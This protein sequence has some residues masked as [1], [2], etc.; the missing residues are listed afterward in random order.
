MRWQ[1]NWRTKM[2]NNRFAIAVTAIAATSTGALAQNNPGSFY[3]IH[4]TR[5][6]IIIDGNARLVVF[7]QNG[8]G[9]T[10][11]AGLGY[12]S[13]PNV[14][15]TVTP[16]GEYDSVLERSSYSIGKIQAEPGTYTMQIMQE[17]ISR[18]LSITDNVGF[19]PDTVDTITFTH[20]PGDIN[21]DGRKDLTDLV[22]FVDL[23]NANVAQIQNPLA[24]PP[25][26]IEWI[27]VDYNGDGIW[28][29]NDLTRFVNDWQTRTYQDAGP[30]IEI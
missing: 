9:S 16:D 5:D 18:D 24:I 23:F 25:Q 13:L 7:D 27:N 20:N 30:A 4:N 15:A 14:F 3:S 12:F 10:Q 19:N 8:T 1:T 29:V 2:L 28:G 21:G 17:P 6:H 22:L 11:S 26:S